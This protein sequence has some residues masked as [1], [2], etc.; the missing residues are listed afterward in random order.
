MPYKIIPYILPM[1]TILIVASLFIF[2]RPAITGF[3][4]AQKPS[5]D[6]QIRITAAEVLPENAT[7]HIFL[8]KDNLLM[9]E[10]LTSDISEFIRSYTQKNLQYIYGINHELNYEGYGFSGSNVFDISSDA[11]AL[12]GQY[13]LKTEILYLGKV[14]SETEQEVKI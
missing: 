3:F 6:A 9:K 4:V 12:K 5:L 10:I 11:G 8:E 14:V 1:L 13:T 7:I 2:A